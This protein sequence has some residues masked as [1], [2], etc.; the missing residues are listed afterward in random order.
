ITIKSDKAIKTSRKPVLATYR[1]MGR[2]KKRP[3]VINPT[4]NKMALIIF[5]QCCVISF[6][7]FSGC[8]ND[9]INIKGITAIS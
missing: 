1:K 6:I 2:N 4:I 5:G 8:N 9:K 3:T 7:E